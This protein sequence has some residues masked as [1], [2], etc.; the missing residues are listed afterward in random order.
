MKALILG[1]ATILLGSIAT[2]VVA[3]PQYVN[4]G[5]ITQGGATREFQS[6]IDSQSI[7]SENGITSFRYDII[8]RD[9]N[10]AVWNH[11]SANAGVNCARPNAITL[12]QYENH[13]SG[14]EETQFRLERHNNPVIERVAPNGKMAALVEVAC[15]AQATR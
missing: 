9:A 13:I 2:S 3:Q 14:G 5:T 10:G 12:Y 8:V 1:S 11:N 7:T 6:F 15:Q 4:R